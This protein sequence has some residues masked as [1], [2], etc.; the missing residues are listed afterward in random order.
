MPGI[1]SF[2][3]IENVTGGSG[4]NS[5][6]GD[7]G[8]NVLT[9]GLGVDTLDGGDGNRHGRY[10]RRAGP[11]RAR[12]Q[13]ARSGR[14]TAVPSGSD[15]LS[16]VEIIEHGGGRYLLVDPDRPQRLRRPRTRRLQHATRP[17]DTI[18]FAAAPTGPVDITV[19]TNQDLDFTIPYDVPTTVTLSGTGS[20]H[21]TT[22]DGADFVVTGDGADTIHTGGGN[23][24]VDAGAG[25]D[26][27]I[28]GQGGG[29]DV[30]DGGATGPTAI[31]S[32]I[33]RRPTALPSISLPRTARRSQPSTHDDAGPNVDTIG[34][35][36]DAANNPAYTANMPVG[37]AE[38]VDIGTDVL[39]NIQNATGGAG[40]DTIIGNS[41]ANVS[42]AAAATTPSLAAV[43]PTRRPI[44]V[45]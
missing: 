17:G 20:A 30:Y 24:V 11:V 14:W 40:D 42:A 23:D 44:P 36:I 32:A 9:G 18:I 34:D 33:R 6:T 19:N 43:A 28:G 27:I 15:T 4:D 35:L 45:R 37:Y 21:V 38:G 13:S 16:N 25:D 3:S 41:V 7:A 31:R 26:D 10:T 2:T 1:A 12:L 8:D 29:D 22:G 5:L 39:I